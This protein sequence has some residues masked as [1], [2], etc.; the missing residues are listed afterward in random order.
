MRVTGNSN[1]LTAV[2]VAALLGMTVHSVSAQQGMGA[3]MGMA[4][5]PEPLPLGFFVTS[6]GSGNGGDL[7]GLDGADA[8][9]QSLADAAGAG[10]RT[11]RAYLSTQASGSES[12]V[13]AID[14]I[15]EGPWGNAKGIPVAANIE[16]LLYDN[17]NLNYQM[18]L[19][20]KGDT[21]NSRAH[22]DDP[23]MHDVL[24]GT[25]ID[26]TAFPAGDDMTCSNWTSSGE[27]IAQVGHSDRF[28]GT[29]PGSP[30]NAAH[31]SRGTADTP[32]QGCSQA[33]LEGTG[34]AGFYY[35]FAAD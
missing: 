10:G 15:G 23:N 20:E 7:G 22:G 32:T 16:A 35:C 33:A 27:G 25:R 21:I 12:A 14:R 11:W 4:A 3:G 30:W 8:H 28:R 6:V 9:C 2:G 31:A 5:E 26:G 29:A 13:N 19:T 1:R 18:S 17:S 34:G 24:T